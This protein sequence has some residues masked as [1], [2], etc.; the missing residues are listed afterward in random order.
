MDT[1]TII[2]TTTA[3]SEELV[4]FI[5]QA[6]VLAKVAK[7]EAGE[8]F[9]RAQADA[10]EAFA[11][12]GLVTVELPDGTLVTVVSPERLTVDVEALAESV[13]ATVYAKVTKTSV[14]LAKFKAAVEAGL[15]PSDIA[16]KVS[17]LAPSEPSL[18]ITAKAK[19]PK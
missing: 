14:D 5:A 17:T 11:A 16:D 13:P 6:A 4:R 15:I 18:R 3:P 12:S 1:T 8:A 9:D 10:L 19:A 7:R 2:P